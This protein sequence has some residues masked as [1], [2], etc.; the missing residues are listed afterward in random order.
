MTI[1][2]SLDNYDKH[3]NYLAIQANYTNHSKLCGGKYGAFLKNNFDITKLP[4]NLKLLDLLIASSS[5]YELYVHLP[6]EIFES[7]ENYP[8]LTGDIDIPDSDLKVAFLYDF[9][10]VGDESTEVKDLLHPYDLEL[11]ESFVAKYKV[12]KEIDSLVKVEHK[13]GRFF[14]PCEIYLAHWR[15]YILIDTIT[16]CKFIENYLPEADGIKYFSKKFIEK[17]EHWNQQYKIYLDIV[18]TYRSVITKVSN[19]DLDVN[20]FSKLLD[21]LNIEKNDIDKVIENLLIIYRNFTL[22]KDRKKISD[23]DGALNLLQQDIYFM[24]EWLEMLGDKRS[25]I[26][27]KWSYTSRMPEK[28]MQLIDVLPRKDI[29]DKLDVLRYSKYYLDQI[30]FDK[31]LDN[32]ELQIESI[33]EILSTLETSQVWIRKF[34]E[35]HQEIQ[36]TKK[37]I[38]FDYPLIVDSLLVLTIRTESILKERVEFL[39]NKHVDLLKDVF[40]ELAKYVDDKD[41]KVFLNVKTTIDANKNINLT[42]LE[43]KPADIFSSINQLKLPN[44]LCK[45]R[46]HFLKSIL[47]FITSRNYFAHHYYKDNELNYITSSLG[48]EVLSACLMTIIF[49]LGATKR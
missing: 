10:F 1:T 28:W 45:S 36:S 11:K 37:R 38:R 29:I 23:L 47:I 14:Y 31:W 27:E 48:K 43:N 49:S 22:K 16:D 7:W 44:H 17:N 5:S 21:L 39:S 19:Q 42:K 2:L 35:L 33:F 9:D 15:A 6:L 24:V 25:E 40:E 12:T 26:Y 34:C 46:Q 30:T 32:K 41:K 4:Y 3:S 18:S 8:K 20:F 13:N